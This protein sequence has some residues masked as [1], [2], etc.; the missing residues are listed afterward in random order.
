MDCDRADHRPPTVAYPRR[1]SPSRRVRSAGVYP[2]ATNVLV[3][4]RLS[5]DRDLDIGRR[6]ASRPMYFADLACLLYVRGVRRAHWPRDAKVMDEIFRFLF[7][8][9]PATAD[10]VL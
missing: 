1:N 2:A 10:P 9:P 4:P 8:R 5:T 3:N 7:L 6:R